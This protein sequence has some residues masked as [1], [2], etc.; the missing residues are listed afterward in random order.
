VNLLSF[1]HCGVVLE[2]AIYWPI[3]PH[4]EL[5]E[6]VRNA[7][8]AACDKVKHLYLVDAFGLPLLSDGIHLTTE[9]QTKVGLMLMEKYISTGEGRQALSTTQ[10]QVEPS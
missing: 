10:S 9:A 7:Q 5:V 4:R 2:V 1:F 6:Q 8:K 3:A